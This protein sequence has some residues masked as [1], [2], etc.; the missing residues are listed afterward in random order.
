MSVHVG[1]DRCGLAELIQPLRLS[2][3]EDV[4]CEA[5]AVANVA[6]IAHMGSTVII[7]PKHEMTND[8]S[9]HTWQ[10]LTAFKTHHEGKWIKKSQ[11]GSLNDHRQLRVEH[12]LAVFCRRQTA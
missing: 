1:N 2:G 9:T 4:N 8:M 10:C 5:S 3:G 12:Q 11:T 7:S 6:L